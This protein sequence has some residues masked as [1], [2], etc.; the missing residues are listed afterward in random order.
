M[1]RSYIIGGLVA[2]A[3]IVTLVLLYSGGS[4]KR[5][6][7]DSSPFGDSPI[8]RRGSEGFLSPR[9]LEKM[10]AKGSS[11]KGELEMYRTYS[12]Y[13]HDSRP[14]TASMKDLTNP[15]FVEQVPLPIPA[16]GA[17]NEQ[18][19]KELV[20]K[21][22]ASGKSNEDI[23]KEIAKMIENQPAF[24]FVLNRHTVTEGDTLVATLKITKNGSPIPYTISSAELES[25]PSQG[26]KGLGSIS[27]NDNG[28]A[29][30]EKAG[31]GITT[32]S[33]KA[34]SADK[35]YWG[36]LTIKAKVN[37]RGAKDVAV[38]Q[39][40][41]YSSPSAPAVF[42]NSFSERLQDGSLVID[43]PIE[44]RRECRYSLQAN[45][46][47]IDE[48]EP[49]HWAVVQKVLDPGRQIVSFTFFG[50]IFHDGGYSGKFQIRDI[51][52]T[53][54]NMPYPA[55]WLGDPS[56]ANQI[57]NTPAVNEPPIIYIPFNDYAY[58]TRSYNLDEFSNQEYTSAEKTKRLAELEEAAK[59]SRE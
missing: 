38:V 42:Q 55:K 57:A 33:W 20:E 46:Y 31:D 10:L 5:G 17:A 47:S 52:G 25:D 28:V 23:E 56:K 58:T 37:V 59:A 13:P 39:Q 29:P 2:I 9:E 6:R 14:L 30:D 4:G 1:K 3:V 45:L 18:E 54:E 49:T 41:F 40:S 21:M 16:P 24:Q 19:I 8:F 51:R 32:F 22:Q 50:K 11:P 26:L 43:I 27:F 44:V 12:Q 35:K 53:C 15:W 48:N 34:P 7:L 36:T